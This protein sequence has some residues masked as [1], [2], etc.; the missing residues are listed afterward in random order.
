[1]KG[2]SGLATSDYEEPLLEVNKEAT[3]LDGV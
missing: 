1:M 3:L 2:T